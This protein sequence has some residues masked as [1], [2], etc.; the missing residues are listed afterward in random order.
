MSNTLS[1]FVLALV[2][3]A[4]LAGTVVPLLPGLP[5]IWAAA[6]AYGFFGGFTLVDAVAMILISLLFAAGVVAKYVLAGR[7]VGAI[8]VPRSTLV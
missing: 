6:L 8:R 3:A 7:R 1:F 5:L 4:G 2:M